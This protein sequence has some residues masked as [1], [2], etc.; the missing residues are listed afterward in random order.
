MNVASMIHT[1]VNTNRPAMSAAGIGYA[2]DISAPMYPHAIPS[3]VAMVKMISLAENSQKSA[4][5]VS[6][7]SP[8]GLRASLRKSIGR[9][10]SFPAL[11]RRRL[12]VGKQRHQYSV[13]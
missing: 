11:L 7:S 1:S 4:L 8:N 5:R 10:K 9:E 3:A 2:R 13:G 6:S 12:P